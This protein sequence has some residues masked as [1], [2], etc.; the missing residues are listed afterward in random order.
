MIQKNKKVV[1]LAF[2]LV[3]TISGILMAKEKVDVTI[4]GPYFGFEEQY[5]QKEL[6]L[7]SEEMNITIK[8][9]PNVDVETYIV[10]NEGEDNSPD[11]AIMPNPQGVTNLGERS[12]VLPI[13]KHFSSS[14]LESIYPQH[15]IDINTSLLTNINYGAWLRLFPNSLIW[16]NVDKY[17]AIGSPE[18]SS[19]EELLKITKSIANEGKEP[20]CLD[21][22]SGVATGW[23]PSNW[24]E[25]ILLTRYGPE[26]YDDWWTLEIKASSDEMLSVFKDVGD[27]IFSENFVFGG[28]KRII[29]KE[30]RNL[31][32]VLM[33]PSTPCIFIWGG[34]YSTIYFP[35]QYS[36]KNDYDFFLF[37]P[38]NYKNSVVGI[39][40]SLVVLNDDPVVWAVMEK[41][42]HKN[43]GIYW[44]NQEDSTFIPANIN[45][46]IE[47]IKNPLTKKESIIIREAQSK[48]LFKFDA[49]E[50]MSRPIGADYLWSMLRRYIDE[51]NSS[52][53]NLAKE[54]DMHY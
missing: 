26:V 22:A 27:L 25:D 43:F 9:Y 41:L 31:P 28:N 30:F 23:I 49:S 53:L 7:I 19:Y 15:L 2:F 37:P 20:W 24:I 12:L 3:F 32:K 1:L 45:S 21:R 39:G 52:L 35:D 44:M 50:L 16:Y 5:F 10:D 36:Y 13:E 38:I 47:N 17:E 42:L 48:N 40:D 51:G 46:N 33:D 4:Y 8:Y 14:Y 6:D 54:L 29:Q 34:H 18:I 11:I